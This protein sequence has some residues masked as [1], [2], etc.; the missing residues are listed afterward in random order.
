VT[1]PVVVG[2]GRL[3][4]AL[5]GI[6]PRLP[7]I[8]AGDAAV[9]LAAATLTMAPGIA[10]AVRAAT[11][12]GC[13]G[14]VAGTV[15]TDALGRFARALLDEAGIDDRAVVGWGDT[16]ACEVT[17]LER[18][19][20]RLVLS[21]DGLDPE[22][23]P[24]R[25]DVDAALAGAAALLVDATWLD[26]QVVAARAARARRLPVIAD[27]SD[28][29]GGLGELI[30]LA[31]VLIASERVAAE[32]APRAELPEAL[33]Q[34]RAL[35]PRAVIVTLGEAGVIGLH[36]E[37]LVECPAFPVDVVDATG[38]GAVFHGAFAAALLSDLPLAR[39]IEVGAASAALSCRGLGRWDAIPGRDEILAVVRARS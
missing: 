18:G 35:G 33:A 2:L 12:F 17:A 9:E 14:R 4:V 30:G 22:G 25:I 27:V 24:P 37:T 21:H 36:G 38:A 29:T 5:T 10:V 26:A 34:L 15:A 28:V 31:D 7:E 3:G 8:G 16:A 19:G 39:C 6:T 13:A 11:A 23:A 32:L 1:R 20:R